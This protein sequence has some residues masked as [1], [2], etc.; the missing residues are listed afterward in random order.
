MI[1]HREIHFQLTHLSSLQ[2]TSPSRTNHHHHHPELQGC[3]AVASRI[4][5]DTPAS[6]RCK[7][8]GV[9]YNSTITLGDNTLKTAALYRR[10]RLLNSQVGKNPRG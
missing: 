5:A 3:Q 10:P 7:F 8:V 1:Q 9:Q 4:W 2:R 6:I